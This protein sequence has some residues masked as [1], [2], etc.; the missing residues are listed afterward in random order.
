MNNKVKGTLFEREICDILAKNGYWV[1]FISPD[2]RGAQPFDIIA[3]KDG[4]AF[5][6]DCKT[7]DANIF[8]ISRLEDNQIMAFE[9][10]I[11]CGNLTPVLFVR[12]KNNIY[13]VPYGELAEK[14]KVRL[15]GDYC[16]EQNTN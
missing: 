11:D 5:A 16:W 2:A 6:A 9:K 14:E 13:L 12:H 8:S 4:M 15:N 1:H 10:W 7:C 3:V